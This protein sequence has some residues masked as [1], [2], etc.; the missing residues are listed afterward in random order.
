[1]A[2]PP[3]GPEEARKIIRDCVKAA[4]EIR[5]MTDRAYKFLYLA[6]GFIA[7]CDKQGFAEY[8]EEPGSLKKDIF[9]YQRENQ[10]R[11]FGPEDEDYD[12]FMQKK[13][14]YHTICDCLK[15]G[16]EYKLKPKR[17]K[18]KEFDFGM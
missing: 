11:N 8:Y 4:K 1:M 17:K 12:Y 7:H 14:I 9:D 10:Y 3:C 2:I 15:Q 5:S 18:E 16:I 6:D 13:K